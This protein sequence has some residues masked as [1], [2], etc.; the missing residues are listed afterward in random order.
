MVGVR[1]AGYRGRVA[2]STS[3]VEVVL[4]NR[5]SV[6]FEVMLKSR[7][8]VGGVGISMGS[9]ICMMIANLVTVQ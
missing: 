9:P 1:G 7:M 3:V 6:I 5:M 2:G 4:R 8:S